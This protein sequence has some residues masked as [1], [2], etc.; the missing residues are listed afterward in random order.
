MTRLWS[1]NFMVLKRNNDCSV[2]AQ[3]GS[4]LVVGTEEH[5]IGTDHKRIDKEFPKEEG[6]IERI[7]WV[8]RFS[9]TE[10]L[11][12]LESVDE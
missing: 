6:W 1:T 11:K 3:G 5:A 12:L 4:G 10:L 2:T 7:V 8:T 9:K